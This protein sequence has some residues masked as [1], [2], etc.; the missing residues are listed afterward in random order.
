MIPRWN[1]LPR[2][3]KS[4]DDTHAAIASA[5]FAH[6]LINHDP[7]E[8]YEI[9][10]FERIREWNKYSAKGTETAC[11]LALIW[12]MGLGTIVAIFTFLSE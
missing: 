9:A 10:R 2:S 3:R 5:R 1:G 7:S 6:W 11:D 12:F 4:D 8:G